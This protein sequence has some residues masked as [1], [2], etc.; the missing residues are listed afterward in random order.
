MSPIPGPL[1]IAITSTP[2]PVPSV[3]RLTSKWPCVACLRM[4]VII[5]VAMMATRPV[6]VSS[7]PSERA[8]LS[9]ERR[10]DAIWLLSAMAMNISYRQ[11]SI[12]G[13]VP[14]RAD[15][16]AISMESLLAPESPSRSRARTDSRVRHRHYHIFVR[17]ISPQF[18]AIGRHRR[19]IILYPFEP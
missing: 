19:L 5:S 4:L 6:R 9:A 10:E 15:W 16:R 2:P 12:I 13:L 14:L 3:K 18:F 17:L 8:R 7:K 11:P 1:S